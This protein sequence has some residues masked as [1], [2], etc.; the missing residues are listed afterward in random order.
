MLKTFNIRYLQIPF[1]YMIDWTTLKQ[2][3]ES[4]I[5]TMNNIA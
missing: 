2:E 5:L 1:F 3:K 4:I